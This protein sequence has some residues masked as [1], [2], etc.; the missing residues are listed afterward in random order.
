[1]PGRTDV[2]A[3][4][5][6]FPTLDQ[7]AKKK[8][9][10]A[11]RPRRYRIASAAPTPR[12]SEGNRYF[13]RGGA[14]D[15]RPAGRWCSRSARRQLAAGSRVDPSRHAGTAGHARLHAAAGATAAAG[16]DLRPGTRLSTTTPRLWR[17]AA[18]VRQPAAGLWRA[19][20]RRL[21][22]RLRR[23]A[24]QAR[25]SIDAGGR[26]H[27]LGARARARGRRYVCLRPGP[28][29]AVGDA[30]GGG[31]DDAYAQADK[32]AFRCHGHAN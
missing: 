7:R 29:Q 5:A 8:A 28:V 3:P 12:R 25:R 6:P 31:A 2:T 26:G 4:R 21:S 18:G 14:S 32:D 1:M 9:R 16:T 22:A 27:R 10:Q 30:D 20:A 13:S 23:T 17:P 24:T 15:D 11:G 19:A